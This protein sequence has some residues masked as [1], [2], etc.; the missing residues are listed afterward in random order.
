MRGR[1]IVSG[2]SGGAIAGGENPRTVLLRIESRLR[3]L[4]ELADG[5]IAAYD[6]AITRKY[7]WHEFGDLNLIL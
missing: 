3:T 6:E 4:Q 7:L 5:L 1:P 2:V